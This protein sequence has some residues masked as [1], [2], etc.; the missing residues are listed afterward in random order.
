MKKTA[1]RSPE[2]QHIAPQYGFRKLRP[3]KIPKAAWFALLLSLIM[4]ISLFVLYGISFKGSGSGNKT[5]LIYSDG[6]GIPE[7]SLRNCLAAAGFGYEIIEPD[8]KSGKSGNVYELPSGYS[9]DRVVICAIG[10]D[11][12]KVM[13]DILNSRAGNVEG[14][15]LIN[16]E[17]PG[18]A[19]LEGYTGD[20]P[21]VPCAIFGFDNKAKAANELSGAQMIFEKISGVDTMYGHSTQRGKIFH[22]KVYV[23]PNQMRYLSLSS[24]KSGTAK[25]MYSPAFQS[26]LAQYLGTTF[27][28]GYSAARVNLWNTVLVF[29]VFMAFA[30]LALF[31]FMV[32]VSV[33]DK[34]SRELK[35]RDSLGAIIFL[36]ISG[37]IALTG[38]VLSFIP[39]TVFLARYIA[40]Y[41]PILIISLMALAQIKIIANKKIEYVRKD[42]GPTLFAASVLIGVVEIMIIVATALNIT[43]F[44]KKFKDNSNWITTLLVFVLMSLSAVALVLADK[45]S[46]FSGQGATAYF[47]SPLYFAEG[48]IPP[49]VLLILGAI[50]GNFDLI[51]S[52][53][54][55]LALGILPFVCATPIKRISDFY[56]ITGL[57]FGLVAALVVFVA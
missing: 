54:A 29:A 31:L 9:N 33:P 6:T 13:N 49:A 20:Y 7:V 42:N 5:L 26:E 50:N 48:L 19:S 18:N 56:E 45:K 22:S 17:Y 43:N 3:L 28:R 4:A 57:V 35:G 8:S 23:S 27:G 21:A 36:G 14:F 34:G 12:F 30:S 47:G 16:P 52:S 44:E 10:S 11:A 38:A 1:A 15:V 51:L 40:L 37:W 2:E 24:S 46:R 55:G 25:L 32:P 39:K 41:S 53:V